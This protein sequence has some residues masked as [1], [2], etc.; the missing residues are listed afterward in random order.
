MGLLG[1]GVGTAVANVHPFSNVSISQSNDIFTLQSYCGYVDGAPDVFVTGSYN[2]SDQRVGNLTFDVLVS[3]DSGV[4]HYTGNAYTVT[5]TI[6]PTD[7]YGGVLGASLNTAWPGN[8]NANASTVVTTATNI[9]V[10]LVR[11]S[12]GE[13]EFSGRPRNVTTACT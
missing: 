10:S 7:G 1:T 2:R 12:D 5:Q 4:S 13:V 8:A 9:V 3:F 11:H 6:T